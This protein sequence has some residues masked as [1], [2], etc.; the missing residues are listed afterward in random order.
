MVCSTGCFI[1]DLHWQAAISLVRF[2]VVTGL[3]Y[4]G[5]LWQF[6][7]LMVHYDTS[8]ISIGVVRQLIYIHFLFAITSIVWFAITVFTTPISLVICF[9][10]AHFKISFK[11]KM[12]WKP[13]FFK[14]SF[15]AKNA[16]KTFM[17][18]F[19]KWQNHRGR[20]VIYSSVLGYHVI[21][22]FWRT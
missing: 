1:S 5:L 9:K 12:F 19:S 4:F 2:Y 13:F 6:A 8:V 16:K 21:P 3:L 20:Y 14:S 17:V 22:T 18:F 11:T 10:Q 15:N 7:I